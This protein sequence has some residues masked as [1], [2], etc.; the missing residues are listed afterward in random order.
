MLKTF[1]DPV[2]TD[3]EDILLNI[4]VCL[5]LLGMWELTLENRCGGGVNSIRK[6]K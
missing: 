2:F 6:T 4:D 3:Y 1:P 5:P